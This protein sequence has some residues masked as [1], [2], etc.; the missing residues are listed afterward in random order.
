MQP[1]FNSPATARVLQR[2]NTVGRMKSVGGH[3]V[4]EKRKLV[5]GGAALA[6]AFALAGCAPAGYNAA[7]YGGGGTQP[8]ADTQDNNPSTDPQVDDGGDPATADNQA[9]EL[10]PEQ[11]T[12]KLN[13]AK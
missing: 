6:A 7:E 12:D 4:P 10:T 5:V 1:F 11:T 13:A 3:V 9:G 2:G 8:V